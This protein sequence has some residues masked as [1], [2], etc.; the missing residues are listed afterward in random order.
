MKKIGETRDDAVGEA[1]D[2]VCSFYSDCLILVV[3][4]IQ[5]NS[6]KPL[7]PPPLVRGRCP[8]GGGGYGGVLCSPVPMINTDDYDFFFFLD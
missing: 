5:K 4:K 3:L 2:K 1:F 7:I 8:E 6:S